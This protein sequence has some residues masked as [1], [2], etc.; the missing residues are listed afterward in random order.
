MFGACVLS[1]SIGYFMGAFRVSKLFGRELNKVSVELEK[2]RRG[3]EQFY[4]KLSEEQ[5]GGQQ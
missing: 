5:E 3:L 2:H 4:S 1:F